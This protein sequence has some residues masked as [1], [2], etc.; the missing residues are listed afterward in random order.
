[1]SI[2]VLPPLDLWPAHAVDPTSNLREPPNQTSTDEKYLAHEFVTWSGWLDPKKG[3]TP[4][5]ARFAIE[6]HLRGW[7]YHAS[8]LK[9][10]LARY[11]YVLGAWTQRTA[12]P[13]RTT[14]RHEASRGPKYAVDDLD[15]IWAAQWRDT[16]EEKLIDMATLGGSPVHVHWIDDVRAGVRRPVL[17]R[18]PHEAM[19]FRAAS[20]AWPGGWYAIT[21]D[22]GIVRMNF[23]DGH[24]FQLAHG[25]RWHET[26]A[27][28][29]LG[30][31]FV[32]GK[33][34]E[35]DE[36]GLSE[37]AGRASIVGV[38]P[39]DIAVGDPVG[40]AFQKMIAAL[41]RARTATVVTHD[42]EVKPVQIVSDTQ[43][44]D[45]YSMRQ[46]VKVGLAIL[47]KPGSMAPNDKGVY[48]PLV[49]Y[50]VDE[51]LTDKDHEATVR[52][53]MG[54][55]VR[56]YLD[57]NAINSDAHLVG[58]RYADANAK[59]KALAERATLHASVIGAQRAA[60][61]D[62]SQEDAD[63]LADQL[64]TPH[65][66]LGPK[67]AAPA[68]RE[69]K[70]PGE[71]GDEEASD[72]DEEPLRK[73][74]A[75]LDAAV[76]D[77]D[78]LY[79]REPDGGPP[80]DGDSGESH[81]ARL[82]GL[83]WDES[84]HKRD[85]GR[86]SST[87]RSKAAGEARKLT[88][89][90]ITASEGAKT[91]EHHGDAAKQH[92][93]AAAQHDEAAKRSRKAEHRASHER[94]AAEHRK[95]AAEHERL[96][97]SK[98][99]ADGPKPKSKQAAASGADTKITD[100]HRQEH[101]QRLSA[102]L[103]D[104]HGAGVKSAEVRDA[105][106]AHLARYGLKSRDA[107]AGAGKYETKTIESGAAGLHH[108]DGR[109]VINTTQHADAVQL[110]RRMSEEPR[111]VKSAHTGLIGEGVSTKDAARDVTHAT[112]GVHVLHHEEIHGCSPALGSSY[113][114]HGRGIEE[115]GTEILA[116]RVSRDWVGVP[117]ANALPHQSVDS[118]GE[119]RYTGG[120]GAYGHEIRGLMTAVHQHTGGGPD[121][122]DRCERAFFAMRGAGYSKHYRS[123][124][125][126][127]RHFVETVKGPNGAAT[128]KPQREALFRTLTHAQGALAAPDVWAAGH[129]LA[130][131]KK[132]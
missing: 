29:A 45:R 83:D 119:V 71:G 97:S 69:S 91:A 89:G 105:L 81:A 48:T 16:Y 108:W 75:G 63:A 86:F 111:A 55:L 20:P 6:F 2:A 95:V 124:D 99:K 112:E 114:K 126:Q 43:F 66:K 18:W 125:D 115:A 96:A 26:A 94:V 41:G 117:E 7:P 103:G 32:Q 132:S 130:R 118:R 128:T 127:V 107:G 27:V 73:A 54:G 64:S 33:L 14:W 12:P 62:P 23:G 131:P 84:K 77:H 40:I 59:A 80:D 122:G 61:L 25:Q 31:L 78:A 123:P 113:V 50:S 24:W 88:K 13:L 79:E 67:Q 65:V 74:L 102:A 15:Q 101:A 68:A 34:A 5:E 100:A 56:P 60:G 72:E 110:S 21:N 9:R 98:P 85:K 90:A 46:I 17:K 39:G 92:R 87:G 129:P 30:E 11:A 44:F 104:E 109:V 70:T 3:W 36:A 53:W 10:H 120:H 52:G 35:R 22:S 93:D 121:V 4:P 1:M 19:F 49:G 28:L 76:A 38:L 37:A 51:A 106:R 42:S 47:G 57:V 82:A 8:S 116:R 58:E